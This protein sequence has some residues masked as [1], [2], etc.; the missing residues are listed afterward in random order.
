MTR[1]AVG[2]SGFGIMAIIVAV[3]R[4]WITR[5]AAIE[6]LRTMLDVLVAATCYHGALPHFLNGRTGATIPFTRKDDGGDLVETSL[7]VHGAAVRA[8]STFRAT[9]GDEQALRGRITWLW[10]EVEWD[11]Y[12]QGGRRACSTGTGAPQRLGHGSRDPRL[13]RVPG[14]LCAGGGLAALCHRTASVYHGGFASGACISSTAIAITASSCRSGPPAADR[15]S[16]RIIRS[17]A[18]I[19]AACRTGTPITGSRIAAMSR[20]TARTASPIPNQHKGYG[21]TCWGLTASDDP[22]GYVAH[23][24]DHDNGTISPT[25][26]HRQPAVRAARGAE[27]ASGI[28]WRRMA[29]GSGA[30]MA[31]S[32]PSA[33]RA[34]GSPIPFWPS[35]RDRSSS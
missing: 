10:E 11:W 25:A 16:S 32:M 9:G 31:S 29:S 2:G 4:G 22:D 15:C 8:A 24:P 20:S 26:A 13:E 30:A 35:I 18:W 19:R 27:H 1:P 28:S 3:E 7:S 23:A 33:S 12:T 14:D 17:A 6:R 5:E 21:P 34:T